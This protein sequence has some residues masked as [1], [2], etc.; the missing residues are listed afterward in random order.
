M[1]LGENIKKYRKAI[2]LTQVE[3]AHVL[4]TTQKVITNYECG[5]NNPLAAAI[6]DIA[7]A[8]GISIDEL[9]GTTELKPALENVPQTSREKKMLSVFKTLEAGEQRAILKQAEGLV[10]RKEKK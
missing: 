3:L 7:N 4:G 10:L 9:Y 6:P 5:L 1:T 8:L 2:G